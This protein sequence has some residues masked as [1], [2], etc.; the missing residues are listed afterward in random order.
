MQKKQ[1]SRK[2]YVDR[3]RGVGNDDDDDEEEVKKDTFSLEKTI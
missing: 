3:K 2:A 1:S